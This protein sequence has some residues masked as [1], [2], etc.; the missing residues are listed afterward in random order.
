MHHDFFHRLI[1]EN[2]ND[3]NAYSSGF[4]LDERNKYI[5]TG[6]QL[7]VMVLGFPKDPEFF[8]EIIYDPRKTARHL[9]KNGQTGLSEGFWD[10]LALMITV[11]PSERPEAA[12]L[13]SNTPWLNQSGD[14]CKEGGI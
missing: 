7:Y 11:D 13:L 10:L 5:C 3:D 2:V 14:D 9:P 1:I 4:S 12:D 8:W 6:I